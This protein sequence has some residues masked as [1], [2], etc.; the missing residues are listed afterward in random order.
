VFSGVLEG[1]L[2]QLVLDLVDDPTSAKDADLAGL[3][4]DPDVDVLVTGDASICGLD[5]VL[6]GPDELLARDLLFGVEL[7]EGTDEVS[8]HDDLRS[9]CRYS[10][11]RLKK[12]RGG[13]PRRGAAFRLM[14]SIHPEGWTLNREDPQSRADADR[15]HTDPPRR[16]HRD[17]ARHALCAS[18][19]K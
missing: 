8:T 14:R 17:A 18:G 6:D 19:K 3:G 12:K 1:D 10:A 15:R 4:V 9:L 13:H 5:A 16:R 2:G 11:A 7:E